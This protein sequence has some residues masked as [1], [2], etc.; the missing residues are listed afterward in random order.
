MNAKITKFM[1]KGQLCIKFE[2]LDSWQ[3]FDYI[4]DIIENTIK[5]QLLQFLPG[6]WVGAKWFIKDRIVFELIHNDDTGN[7]LKLLERQDFI[8]YFISKD[9][10][11]GLRTLKEGDFSQNKNKIQFLENIATEILNEINKKIPPIQAKFKVNLHISLEMRNNITYIMIDDKPFNFC[12]GLYLLLPKNII[13]QVNVESIS[14]AYEQY[15]LKKE[16]IKLNP[17]EEFWGHCSNIQAWVENNYDTKLIH[18]NLAFPLLKRLTE[19]GDP[20]AKRVFKEE[21][22]KRYNS[23]FPSVVKYLEEEGFLEYLSKEELEALK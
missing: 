15:G 4:S 11:L 2:N 19:V 18:Y 13:D 22:A 21:I 3:L 7:Y 16:E 5:A 8:E 10:G 23:G 1:E 14:E 6:D 12:L 17:E 20:L 9:V